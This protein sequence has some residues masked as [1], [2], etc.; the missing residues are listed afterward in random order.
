MAETLYKDTTYSVS[1]LVQSIGHGK[2]AGSQP[3]EPPSVV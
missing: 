3:R 1:L 2:I